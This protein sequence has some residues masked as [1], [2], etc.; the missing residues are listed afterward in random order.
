MVLLSTRG[1]APPRCVPTCTRARWLPPRC[2]ALSRK[3][4]AI[5]G[6]Y[7]ER[8]QTWIACPFASS[9]IELTRMEGVHGPSMLCVLIVTDA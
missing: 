5:S 8:P 4:V 3:T 2:R 7:A 9:D 6:E 1:T